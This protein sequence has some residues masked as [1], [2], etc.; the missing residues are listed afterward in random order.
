MRITNEQNSASKI[1]LVMVSLHMQF[2]KLI[3]NKCWPYALY[4]LGLVF[5]PTPP[6][7]TYVEDEAG[8]LNT[9]LCTVRL[10]TSVQL[11]DV[12]Q[13]LSHRSCSIL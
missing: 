3:I 9:C 2:S 5:L 4:N 1:Q 12:L 13:A 7:Y 6:G 8:K 11:S 10:V